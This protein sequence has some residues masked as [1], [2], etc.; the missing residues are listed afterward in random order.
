MSNETN[1]DA[2]QLTV[3]ANL[4]TCTASVHASGCGALKRNKL[5][6]VDYTF[7][8]GI[9]EMKALDYPVKFCKCTKK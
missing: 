7:A 5:V 9:E 6:S 3:R 8:V 4:H 2:A 1:M